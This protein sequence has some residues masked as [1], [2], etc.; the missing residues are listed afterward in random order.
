MFLSGN[1]DVKEMTSVDL[2]TSVQHPLASQEGLQYFFTVEATNGAGLTQTISSDGI[3]VDTSPPVIAGVHHGVN[4]GDEGVPQVMLQGVGDHLVFFWD[5]PYDKESGISSV[6]WCAGTNNNSCDIV[7]L[8]SVGIEDTSVRYSFSKP[9]ASGTIVFIKLVVSNGAGMS[10]EVLTPP[11]LIDTTPPLIGNVTIG[12]SAGT[13]NFKKE[14]SISAEWSG[15]DDESHL[16]HFEWA[17]CQASAKDKCVSP[18]VNVGSKTTIR[19]DAVGLNYGVSYVVVIRA[20]NKVG[21]F[22]EATSN[23]FILDGTGPAAGTVYDGSQRLKD[24]EFQS[25]TT[26]LSANWSPFTDSNGK[27]VEYDMCVGSN[28]GTCD[29]SDFVSFGMNIRGIITGLSLKHNKRYFITV[30]A[31]SE[32]G[33]STTASSNGVRIDNTPAVKGLVRD[34]QTLTDIDFQAEDTYIYANWDE[35]QDEESDVTT[36]TW[37]AG[38]GKGICDIVPETDVGDRT[39]VSQ[40]IIPALPEGITIFVTV[41]TSNNAGA[42]TMSSSDGFKVDSTVPML[43]K[44]RK[45]FILL[46]FYSKKCFPLFRSTFSHY[47][48]ELDFA[49]SSPVVPLPVPSESVPVDRKKRDPGK[50]VAGFWSVKI[51][52]AFDRLVSRMC[53]VWNY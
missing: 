44:V 15:S 53:A 27:I 33:Y 14:D 8:I 41:S 46:S 52:G 21:M 30:R 38:T 29:V 35:F 4:R 25:S 13:K 36:Y 31:T 16:S 5:M 2:Q 17:I 49:T 34:G 18:Y 3:T 10:S 24:T 20:F 42:P 51:V 11:L 19:I 6:K 39:S 37:C 28:P 48:W 26:Q 43:S 45:M 23:Q 40:Q 22:N 12:N 1:C 32:S 50:E 47:R 9:L 7:S